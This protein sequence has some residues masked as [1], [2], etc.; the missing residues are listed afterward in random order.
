[1]LAS[2]EDVLER[3]IGVDTS[4]SSVVACLVGEGGEWEKQWE[5]ENSPEGRR[6][7]L[8][9]AC[10]LG[11]VSLV[12][13]TTE[14]FSERLAAEAR[15]AG[16]GMFV[17]SSS[18]LKYFRKSEGYEDKRDGLDAYLLGLMGHRGL[19]SVREAVVRTAE[20]EQ[21][22]GLS[23]LRDRLVAQR[24]ELGQRLR[25]VLLA[26]SPEVASRDWQGPKTT[27]ASFLAVLGRWPELTSLGR[28]RV[29]TVTQVVQK[30]GRYPHDQAE[31][32]AR[33][34]KT[35]ARD[36]ERVSPPRLA[37]AGLELAML[38]ENLELVQRQIGQLEQLL[39]EAVLAHPRGPALMEV[40]GIAVVV[41]GG[42]IA[43]VLP[44]VQTRTE[45]QLATYSGLTPASRDSGKS[46]KSR[47]RRF[48]NKRL[49]S[50]YFT[51][52]VASLRVS[53]IDR[54]YYDKKKLDFRGHKAA[55]TKA[56]IALA[57]QR[58]KV[59]YKVLC[60]HDYDEVQLARST[61][62]RQRRA[63]PAA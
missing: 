31:G 53:P 17:V 36:L 63:R 41:A 47:L 7:W 49:A 13:E 50:T 11:E 32:I 18:G 22:R 25:A 15:G 40:H 28:A 2:K 14:S 34:L 56:V 43:E 48:V 5:L 38:R 60:G 33:G 20:E 9:E 3:W 12:L 16:L 24:V 23:R 30:A 10:G 39:R 37:T 29:G 44:R 46:K 51:S 35:W 6:S 26:V 59:I 52:A 8:E 1:M 61:L 58:H 55:H 21:L 42:L 4:E 57:R 45:A 62:D 19:R 27:S 54:A